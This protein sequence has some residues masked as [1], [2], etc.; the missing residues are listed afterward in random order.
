VLQVIAIAAL[1]GSLILAGVGVFA[2]FGGY[3]YQLLS[4]EHDDDWEED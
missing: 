3:W 1:V 2:Y 4:G